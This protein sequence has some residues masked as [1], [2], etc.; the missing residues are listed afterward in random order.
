MTRGVLS[1]RLIKT[2][3]SLQPGSQEVFVEHPVWARSLSQPP[4]TAEVRSLGH[5]G[6]RSSGEFGLR[7]GRFFE[8]PRGWD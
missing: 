2:V 4:G 3:A 7:L 5:G 8:P 6:D 1:A